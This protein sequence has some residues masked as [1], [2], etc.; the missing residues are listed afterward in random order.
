[1]SQTKT[2]TCLFEDDNVHE[3]NQASYDKVKQHNQ[4]SNGTN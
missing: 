3:H 2:T 1:M 4:T